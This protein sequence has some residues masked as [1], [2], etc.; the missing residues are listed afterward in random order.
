VSRS[1]SFAALSSLRLDFVL[2]HLPRRRRP[3]PVTIVRSFVLSAYSSHRNSGPVAKIGSN[4]PS[5]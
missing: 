5:D 4:P 3:A 1:E 2:R